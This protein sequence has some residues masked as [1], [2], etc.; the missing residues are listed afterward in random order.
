MSVV[1]LRTQAGLKGPKRRT[2]FC[3]KQATLEKAH[4]PKPMGKLPRKST[5]QPASLP[6]PPILP[7][8][9]Q[10]GGGCAFSWLSSGKRLLVVWTDSST[11]GLFKNGSLKLL[12]P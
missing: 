12:L 7:S 8:Q 10:D 2:E 9:A 4:W 1:I 11:Q 6:V 5:P 3:F